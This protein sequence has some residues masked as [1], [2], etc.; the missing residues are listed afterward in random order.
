MF[1]SGA[2]AC[3]APCDGPAVGQWIQLDYP[4]GTRPS[5]LVLTDTCTLSVSMDPDGLA[6]YA[7]DT[8]FG[9]YDSYDS[10]EPELKWKYEVN[11]KKFE[12][13]YDEVEG[14]IAGDFL[15]VKGSY[16]TL[17]KTY[18][19]V[20]SEQGSTLRLSSSTPAYEY[21]QGATIYGGAMAFTNENECVK[22]WDMTG[23]GCPGCDF[24]WDVTLSPLTIDDCA[25]ESPTSGVFELKNDAV[26]FNDGYWGRAY[27]SID[28][29]EGSVGQRVA[30]GGWLQWATTS[31][32]PGELGEGLHM[33]YGTAT[34]GD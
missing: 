1:C 11:G 26:Y 23:P 4:A 30:V 21:E 2:I 33:Y 34:I 12:T 14:S 22:S 13:E 27:W 5:V 7:T 6:P 24:A 20:G 29:Y 17:P 32:V 10:G 16:A 15:N 31:Y 25:T 3:S 28:Y 19:R 9:S 18:L 8:G